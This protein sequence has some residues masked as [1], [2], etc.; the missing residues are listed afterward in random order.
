MLVNITN[1]AWYGRSSAPYQH[2]A[3][4]VFRA[5]E[6]DRWVL[7]AAN[8]GISAAIDPRGRIAQRRPYS[9]RTCSTVLSESGKERRRM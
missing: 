9:R 4:Y 2:F 6:T 7:R 5:I 3:N 8:T 1:D